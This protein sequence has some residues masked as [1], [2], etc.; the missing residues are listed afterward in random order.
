[1]QSAVPNRPGTTAEVVDEAIVRIT[2]PDAPGKY[3]VTYTIVNEFGG[4]SQAFVTVTVDPLAPLAYPVVG[5]TVLT[6]SDVL[7]RDSVDVDV[8][9]NVFF[10]DGE[11]RDLGVSLVAGYGT[12]A[13]A[14]PRQAD[15][16]DD[17]PTQP[18][19][20]VLGLPPG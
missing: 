19:H 11:V 3:A 2:P 1:M 6:V 16:G 5:D 7:D 15:P 13:R 17:R 4:T 20:P 8:L 14:A 9:D 12:T 10:A 18:D